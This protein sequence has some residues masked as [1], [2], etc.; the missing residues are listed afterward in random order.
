MT[1]GDLVVVTGATRGLGLGIASR[2]AAEGRHVIATGRRRSGELDDAIAEAEGSA[3][4]IT[5][6]TLDLNDRSSIHPFVLGVTK[7]HG[8]LYGLVNNAAVAH[9]GVLATLHESDITDTVDVNLTNTILLTKSALRSML[10]ARRGRIVN[11][12][13][14]VADTGFSGLSVYGATKAGLLGFTRGLARE[15]GRIGITVNAVAPGYMRTALSASLR[16][17]QLEA[18]VRR[19]PA[20]RLADT[21]DVAGAVAYLLSDE[22]A[23][24]SGTTI[25]VDGGSTA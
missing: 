17:D 22:A 15:V 1:S 19:T 20:G 9:H 4:E 23:M 8:R 16:E 7:R 11:V 24:I 5:F 14:I 21:T 10:P 13:S 12:T 6:E 2:L 3:G 18:I 25:T